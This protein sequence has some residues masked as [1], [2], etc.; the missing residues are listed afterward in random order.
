MWQQQNVY[1]IRGLRLYGYDKDANELKAM[2]LKVVRDYY[3]KWGTARSSVFEQLQNCFA[4]QNVIR[5]HCCLGL[6]PT[7]VQFN[8][9]P[10]DIYLLTGF[11]V[12]DAEH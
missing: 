2:S 6:K 7:Y 8:S 11:T 4:L 9:M 1:L 12:N 10:T 3:E 5:P